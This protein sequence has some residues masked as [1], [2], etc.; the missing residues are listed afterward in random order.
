MN[1]IAGAAKGSK[2]GRKTDAGAEIGGAG[3]PRGKG[4]GEGF[5]RGAGS[6]RLA[7]S[8]VALLSALLLAAPARAEFTKC[9]DEKGSRYWVDYGSDADPATGQEQKTPPR[10]KS[11]TAGRFL[12]L[13]PDSKKYTDRNGITFW[14]DD[15]NK[16]PPEYRGQEQAS[17]PK[18][19]SAAEPAVP[20]AKAKSYTRVA[21]VK[22][23]IFVPVVLVN[24]GRKVSAKM[25]L[26]TG[27][28]STIIYPGLAARLGMN[29][30]PVA[31]G[32]SK[33]ANGSQVTS[34]QANVDLIQVDGSALRNPE[35]IIMPS[36][37]DLGVDG[38]LG[39][40]F[41]RFFHFSV[42]YDN[43]LIV[44]DE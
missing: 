3:L 44:W 4:A 1:S 22:N 18:A 41:L 9:V 12:P 20:A 27:A 40:T 15:E 28:S 43:Q 29:R 17:P 21:I 32:L 2:C 31:V 16:I 14:V 30:N 26:D 23:Q 11:G 7:G 13:L 5:G 35:V 24:K 38:L 37:S 39:N 33:I 8:A 42:D 36:V 25:I 34:Y 6:G 10:C 19:K